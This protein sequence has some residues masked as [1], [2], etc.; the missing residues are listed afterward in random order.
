VRTH[1]RLSVHAGITRG[2]AVENGSLT[3]TRPLSVPDAGEATEDCDVTTNVWNAGAPGS[4]KAATLQQ[5]PAHV[6][7]CFA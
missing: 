1:G 3:S 4:T 7:W 6:Q 5:L 2:G